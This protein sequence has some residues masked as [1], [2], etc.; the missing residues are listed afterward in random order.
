MRLPDTAHVSRPWRIYEIARD[1]ELEDLWAL[2][3]PGGHR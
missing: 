2:P 3:T 1:F